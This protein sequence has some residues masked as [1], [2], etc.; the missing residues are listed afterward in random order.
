MEIELNPKTLKHI[1]TMNSKIDA[2][3]MIEHTTFSSNEYN[4]QVFVN[5][6]QSCLLTFYNC[7]FIA[8]KP[9]MADIIRVGESTYQFH[10]T[11]GGATLCVEKISQNGLNVIN[12]L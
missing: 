5:N 1:I 12:I 2:N 7:N 10:L 6:I 9:T 11:K 4:F 3:K 8:N